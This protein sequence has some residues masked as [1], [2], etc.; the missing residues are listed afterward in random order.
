MHFLF[1]SIPHS[2]KFM[3]YRSFAASLVTLSLF[4]L[5]FPVP[6]YAQQPTQHCPGALAVKKELE[7][8]YK[9]KVTYF[10]RKDISNEFPDRPAGRTQKYA[11]AIQG[12][13]VEN[14]LSSPKT[15]TRMA[16][17]VIQGC[18]SVGM[19]G[20]GRANSGGGDGFVLMPGGRIEAIKCL[21]LS[22]E[23]M[24]MRPKWGQNTCY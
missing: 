6:S 9:V 1:S 20:F 7:Q 15:L 5:S 14:I 24:G 22:E 4:L 19:V 3:M 16:K 2:G 18:D 12:S 17:E 23:R 10:D 13:A 8:K 11:F 21:S